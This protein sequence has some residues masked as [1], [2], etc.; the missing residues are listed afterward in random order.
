[1]SSRLSVFLAELKRRKVT[2]VAVMYVVGGLGLIEAADLLLPALPFPPW[3]YQALVAVVMA[4]FPL[5]LALAWA[6]DL[7]AKGIEVTAPR[8]E[9]EPTSH[10][11]PRRLAEIFVLFLTACVL[12]FY[13][14]NVL[15]KGPGLP[16]R[17][18]GGEL[19]LAVFPFRPSAETVG[20]WSEGAADLLASALDGTAGLT[21]ADPWALW[22]S[23]RPERTARALA[24]TD[25]SE[26]AQL[27]RRAG[28]GRY[29]LGSVTDAGSEIILTLALYVLDQTDPLVKFTFAGTQ[30]EL[31][32]IAREAAVQL[33]AW[34]EEGP[35]GEQATDFQLST[36][37][38]PDALKA[39]LAA[40]EA[41]RRGLLDSADLAITRSLALDSLFA[42][43]L[44]AAIEIRSW[45]ASLRGEPYR[46]MEL[47][48]RAES[49]R[50]GLGERDQARLDAM[51][52][53]VRTDG[54]GADAAVRRILQRDSTD[55]WAWRYLVYYQQ[56][57]GW[58]YGVD[59]WKAAQSADRALILD[60]SHVPT[61]VARARLAVLSGDTADAAAQ[62][63]RL[64]TMD[65]SLVLARGAILGLRGFLADDASFAEI[66]ARL[67]RE[68]VEVFA[69]AYRAVQVSRPDRSERLLR[70]RIAAG[71]PEERGSLLQ[72][73]AR[74]LMAQGRLAA[75]DSVARDN[76]NVP[77][78]LYQAETLFTAAALAGFVPWQRAAPAVAGLE[79]RLSPDSAEAMF[80]QFP[81]WSAGW[82]IGSY[83]A[84]Y[85]DSA[86][87]RRWQ[88]AL[89][90][91]PGGGTSLD[92]R[93]ALQQDMEARL[94]L[95]EGRDS[96]GLALAHQ[97]YHNW[98]I[99]S[100]NAQ[101]NS[102]PALIRALMAEGLRRAHL[103]DSARALLRSLTPPTSF[104]GFLTT[105]GWVELGELALAAG[106]A[107]EA[108]RC[109]HRAIAYLQGADPELAPWRDRAR[110]GLE[111]SQRNGT[112]G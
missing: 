63:A 49:L 22:A 60:P 45:V 67:A 94:A 89:G 53:S 84:A 48:Q 46:F 37:N 15:L 76:A 31:G 47:A 3:A 100:D 58:Q 18:A 107:V 32:G 10:V 28:A 2:R 70:D 35:R 9:G 33:L 104:Y 56:A 78:V 79:R 52:A 54:P 6:L 72:E 11:P 25:P 111:A 81:V 106:E 41:M 103:P 83:H 40:R 55:L 57:Y 86:M 42:P 61:A 71:L 1:M 13:G 66:S 14:V 30:E 98:T 21:V 110:R 90:R 17:A 23:L 29:I 19:N 92:Y 36:A 108:S 91:I 88:A 38:S 105:Q 85:G 43:A 68:R 24:P 75:V 12:A 27:A 93:G 4:G 95:R 112:E 8:E 44:V 34:L 26:A 5:A 82:L 73:L 97:A 64:Q 96:A 69:L 80:T 109:F 102:P 101:E 62:L 99:H 7:T 77:G 51:V 65:T 50:E 87:T 74:H 16:R 20:H 59:G 39:Y